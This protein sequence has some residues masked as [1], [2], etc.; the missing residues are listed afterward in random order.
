MAFSG[1][2][3]PAP[4]PWAFPPATLRLALAA[5]RPKLTTSIST[6]NEPKT[7]SHTQPIHGHVTTSRQHKQQ[8]LLT[9]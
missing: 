9:T 5:V 2:S 8:A 4:M 3:C 7:T 1:S 6:Y